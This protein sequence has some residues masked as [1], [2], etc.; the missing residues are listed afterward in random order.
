MDDNLK[1]RFLNQDKKSVEGRKKRQMMARLRSKGRSV[2]AALKRP[3]GR[4][5]PFRRCAA[6]S[7]CARGAAPSVPLLRLSPGALLLRL[8]SRGAL[9]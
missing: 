1:S 7:R 3:T 6:A 8:D 2:P 5:R 4:Q 9:P